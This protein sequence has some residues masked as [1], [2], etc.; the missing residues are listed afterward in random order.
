MGS[1]LATVLIVDVALTVATDDRLAAPTGAA[2]IVGPI[3]AQ[4]AHHPRFVGVEHARYVPDIANTVN[5]HRG[6]G[7]ETGWT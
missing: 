3:P 7:F 4:V 5:L 6:Y 1:S 2:L